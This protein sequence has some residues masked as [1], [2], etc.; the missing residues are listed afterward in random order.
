MTKRD[1]SGLPGKEDVARKVLRTIK[2]R[3]IAEKCRI[4]E[5]TFVPGAS[6]SVVARRHDVNANLVFA[7]RQKYRQGTL[8]AKKAL[9]R[10]SLPT[11]DLIRIGAVDHAGDVRPLPVVAERTVPA[12]RD[13]RPSGVIEI[14]W[15]NGIKVRV[16]TCIDETALRRVLSSIKDVA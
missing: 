13:P 8:V 16:D 9:A 15:H 14:E 12:V 6:V 11:P 2:R 1:G 10:V 7:W 5:E 3:S 4:V